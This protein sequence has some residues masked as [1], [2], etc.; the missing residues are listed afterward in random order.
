MRPDRPADHAALGYAFVYRSVRDKLGLRRVRDCHL[1][2]GAHRARGARVLLGARRARSARATAR[3]R[4]P[5]SPRSRPHDDVR[6][7][8]VGIAVPGS[9][10]R[11]RGRRRDPHPLGRQLRRLLSTNP[12]A[13]ADDPG[14][15]RA[16][17]T[18]ATSASSTPTAILTITDRK[19]DIIITAGGK[20]ISPS[21]IENRL[22]VSPYVRE[23][24][25]IGDRRKYLTALIG[26]ELDTV[27]DWA[28]APLPS[29]HDLRGPGVEARGTSSSSTSGSQTS[30]ADLAQVETIKRFALLPKE[31]DHEDGELTATQK[32]KRAAI[33]AAVPRPDRG[34]VPMIGSRP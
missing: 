20:N 21:E 3:P 25:V 33:A 26:I 7:G 9:R 34:D 24:I 32:V 4:T 17:C 18:P 10:D 1:R 19:K 8:K 6:I 5:R 23:A 15:R 14:R 30:T 31:L 27:G 29:L 28:S 22:K 13:T 2:R 16:G 12:E 11:D